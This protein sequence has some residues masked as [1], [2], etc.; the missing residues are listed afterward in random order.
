MPLSSH[1][2]LKGNAFHHRRNIFYDQLPNREYLNHF[3][4]IH[5]YFNLF[6]IH[7]KMS[8]KVPT[9]QDWDSHMEPNDD[10]IMEQGR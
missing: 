7:L 2:N 5:Y 1:L 10:Q 9:C 6:V 3:H 4:L 8:S